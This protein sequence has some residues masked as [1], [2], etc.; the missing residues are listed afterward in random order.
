[1]RPRGIKYFAGLASLCLIV[2]ASCLPASAQNPLDKSAE[3][4]KSI[5]EKP[6]ESS[7]QRTDANETFELNID[8]R[9]FTKTNFEASTA[10]DT[11]GGE[12]GVNVRIGVSLTA[13]RIDVLLRNVHGNVRFRG[14]LDRILEVIGKR[15]T[16]TPEVR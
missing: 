11:D 15:S 16:A 12:R 2:S 7:R 9:R 13:G 4:S 8:E 3:K 5:A 6:D 14:T 10:V 1:M